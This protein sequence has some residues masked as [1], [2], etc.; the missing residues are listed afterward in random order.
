M[1]VGVQLDFPGVTLEKYD[2]VAEPWDTCLAARDPRGCCFT[3]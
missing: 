2:E 3:G 1:V